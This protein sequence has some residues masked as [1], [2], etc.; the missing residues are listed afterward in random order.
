MPLCWQGRRE[1][2]QSWPKCPLGGEDE[3]IRFWWST[4]TVLWFVDFLFYFVVVSSCILLLQSTSFPPVLLPGLIV[5][6]HLSH[7][8]LV[9][10]VLFPVSLHLHPLS[11]SDSSLCCS[12]TLCLFVSC[13]H[14][15]SPVVLKFSSTCKK[16]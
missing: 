15:V 7:I 6:P 14:H 9:C 2:L 3:L 16:K 4:V 5:P 10:T 8:I 1:F 13:R 11:S 12:L